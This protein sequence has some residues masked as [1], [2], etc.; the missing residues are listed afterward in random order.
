[1]RGD[2]EMIG[3]QGYKAYWDSIQRTWKQQN[4]VEKRNKTI[5]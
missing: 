2:E 3:A 1:M 4:L 5:G